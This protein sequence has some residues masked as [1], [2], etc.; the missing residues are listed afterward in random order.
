MHRRIFMTAAIFVFI[1]VGLASFFSVR[2][3]IQEEQG[4][5]RELLKNVVRYANSEEL[6]EEQLSLIAGSTKTRILRMDGAS[7]EI[8]YDSAGQ[9]GYYLDQPDVKTALRNGY[10][11]EISFSG[12]ISRMQVA[13]SMRDSQK[14]VLRITKTLPTFQYGSWP[15]FFVLMSVL[16]LSGLYL[17]LNL[18]RRIV[19]PIETISSAAK[20]IV[21]GKNVDLE[22]LDQDTYSELNTLV[23]TLRSMNSH[24]QET[25]EK[26]AAEGIN[27]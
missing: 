11:E 23:V 16:L 26:L 17:S 27:T 5:M 15:L 20:E 24:L 6:P 12:G 21:N 1:V 13:V 18:D 4:T 19:Q 2:I 10:G 22:H 7:G 8:R 25:L 3:T 14:T 9:T